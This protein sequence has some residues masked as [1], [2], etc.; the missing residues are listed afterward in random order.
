MDPSPSE[1]LQQCAQEDQAG[2]DEY[3]ASRPMTSLSSDSIFADSNEP[4]AS[5]D[6]TSRNFHV[7]THLVW[8]CAMPGCNKQ[9]E[10]A[11]GACPMCEAVQYCSHEHQLIDRPGHRSACSK[12]RKARA[13]YKKAEKS[14]RRRYGDAMTERDWRPVWRRGAAWE[15][16]RLRR[17]LVEALLKVNTAQAITLASEHLF[18]TLRLWRT[19]EMCARDVVPALLHRLG[20]VQD[21]Y[22]FCHWWATT[23]HA[24]HDWQDPRAGYLDTKNADVFQGLEIFTAREKDLSHLIVVTLIKIRLLMDLQSVQRAREFAGPHV[25]REILDTIQQH[26][27]TSIVACE[28]RIIERDDQSA[29]VAGLR[30]QILELYTVVT[31]L[32]PHFWPALIE[33][34]EHLKARPVSYKQG[35]EG[36]MQLVLQHNYNAWSETPGAISVIEEFMRPFVVY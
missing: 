1:Y 18:D 13:S 27:I 10:V 15:Y 16:M 9:R 19:D 30:K 23:G 28:S 4:E 11:T 14:L 3:M 32:N 34:G 12:I 24:D 5:R 22:D 26:C 31:E 29:Q 35:D 20:R 21:A 36:Q 2:L 25:P 6:A 8:G 17:S 7:S 33:P